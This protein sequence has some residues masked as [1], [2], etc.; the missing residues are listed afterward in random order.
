MEI[1]LLDA[2]LDAPAFYRLA[3][4]KI[5]EIF[6]LAC[7]TDFPIYITFSIGVQRTTTFL[8]PSRVRRYKIC[9]KISLKTETPNPTK[10][11]FPLFASLKQILFCIHTEKNSRFFVIATQSSHVLT[12]QKYKLD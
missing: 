1:F 7:V 12:V 11:F 5:I 10:V 4:K 8:H 3:R 2:A 6:L 9:M